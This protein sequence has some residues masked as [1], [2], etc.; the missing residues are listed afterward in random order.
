M[1]RPA[2]VDTEHILRVARE[3]FLEQ[4]YGV[5]TATIAR[6]AGI[7]EGSIFKRFPTKDELFFAALGIPEPTWIAEIPALAGQHD[8]QRNLEQIVQKL[9]AFFRELVPRMIMLWSNRAVAGAPFLGAKESPPSRGLS[10]LTG[11]FS[12]E[13]DLGRTRAC[14]PEALAR[15]L[16]GAAQNYVFFELYGV[17]PLGGQPLSAQD[18]AHHIAE[19]LWL[20][21]KPPR[22][23]P[24][25]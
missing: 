5:T 21:L 10:V 2:S 24:R 9:I 20:G 12:R 3:L 17:C 13:A 19:A 1:G 25:S 15:L 8:P 23:R 11:Y 16:L 7:S 14:Q 6:R 18:F 4:G 22:R